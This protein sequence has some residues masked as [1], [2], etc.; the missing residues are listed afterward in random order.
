M[1]AWIRRGLRKDMDPVSALADAEAE[2]LELEREHEETEDENHQLADK[3]ETLE[4][5][6]S[7]ERE[8]YEEDIKDL[9]AEWEDKMDAERELRTQERDR[10]IQAE[11]D[12]ASL[13]KQMQTITDRSV[14]AE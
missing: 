5:E 12:L 1:E 2:I 4:S 8:Q 3:V 9:N 11:A 14:Y 13:K 7:D 10:R 6:L